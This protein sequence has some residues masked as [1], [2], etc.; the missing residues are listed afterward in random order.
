[1]DY[2]SLFIECVCVGDDRLNEV[3]CDL[4]ATALFVRVHLLLAVGLEC[5]GV[6][7]VDEFVLSSSTDDH[8]TDEDW[9][10]KPYRHELVGDLHP[11]LLPSHNLPLLLVH[12]WRPRREPQLDDHEKRLPLDAEQRRHARINYHL[13]IPVDSLIPLRQNL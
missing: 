7:D 13:V 1:M 11:S 10:D 4:P 3:L 9:W 2:N 12:N 5:E 6:R 8:R